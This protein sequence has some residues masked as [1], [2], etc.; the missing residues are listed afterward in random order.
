MKAVIFDTETTGLDAPEVI[1]AAWLPIDIKGDRAGLAEVSRYR[2]FGKHKGAAIR[3]VP[4]DYRRWL[5]NQPDVDPYLAKAL[6]A[7]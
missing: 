3:D 1:E 2:P 7:A 6:R 5:L 4:A